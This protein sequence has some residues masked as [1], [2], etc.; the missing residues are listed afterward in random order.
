[1]GSQKLFVSLSWECDSQ[2]LRDIEGWAEL[3]ITEARMHQRILPAS[4]ASE[5]STKLPSKIPKSPLRPTLT[6]FIPLSNHFPDK[7]ASGRAEITNSKRNG[8]WEMEPIQAAPPPWGE[9]QEISSRDSTR[10][11]RSCDN[12]SSGLR[13]A[14]SS[15]I[16][17][18]PSA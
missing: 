6:H 7:I 4:A 14:N 12:A 9:V 3:A 11:H 2:C 13:S 18:T 17:E 15:R 1:M 16:S 5:T 10:E 8:G